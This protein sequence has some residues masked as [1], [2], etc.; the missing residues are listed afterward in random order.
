MKKG[1]VPRY[2]ELKSN[3][4]NLIGISE[5]GKVGGQVESPGPMIRYQCLQMEG[6][7]NKS[8]KK[9]KMLIMSH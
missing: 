3:L 5:K 9:T 4:V 7:G 6:Y 2:A 1:G 8:L